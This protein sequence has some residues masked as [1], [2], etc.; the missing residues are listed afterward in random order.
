MGWTA[1][2]ADACGPTYKQ[3]RQLHP[4]AA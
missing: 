3:I 1:L 2:Q 4:V